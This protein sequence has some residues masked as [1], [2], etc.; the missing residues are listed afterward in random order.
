[1]RTRI[2]L[3]ILISVSLL[4]GS[5]GGWDN[6]HLPTYFAFLEMP[7]V[8][9]A[10]PVAVEPIES[11]LKAEEQKIETLLS[12]QEEWAQSN[13]PRYAARPAELVFR[14]DP[15]RDDNA[16]RKAFV[17]ALRVAANIKLALFIEPAPS[18]TIDPARRQPYN[19]VSTLPE[20][21]FGFYR[22]TRLDIGEMVS[23]LLVLAAGADEPDFGTD[24]DCWEDS[25][26]EWGKRYHFGNLP[27]GNHSLNITTQAPF[28]MGFY[29]Q[30]S[31]IY[32]AAPFVERTYPL[33][34]IHQFIGL[35]ELA[36]KTD[37]PYWGWRFAGNAL[38]YVQEL[39]NPYH[40]SLLPGVSTPRMLGIYL[41]DMAGFSRMKDDMTVLV[42]NRHLAFERYEIE[43]LFRETQVGNAKS[44]IEALQSTQRDKDFPTWS[45][46]YVRDLVSAEAFAFADRVDQA[47]AMSMPKRYMSDPSYDFGAQGENVDV[48]ED[49]RNLNSE[50]LK[51]LDSSIARLL[52]HFG[53]HSRNLMRHIL[54]SSAKNQS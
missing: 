52:R 1:M 49:A 8:V 47:V 28:H 2:G 36:F 53:V 12:S 40:A 11:F 34:R 4:P 48:F 54:S 18:T 19:L 51:T 20:A 32:R 10:A 9:N 6:H 30:S 39:T 21:V 35:S 24:I 31:L 5:A 45:D 43:M 33:L 44:L 14:A 25:P 7:A 42:S 26:S 50:H 23:P 16:R 29:H 17:E 22:F 15:K 13:L 3:A 38:H 46:N 37:H 41:L 27:F